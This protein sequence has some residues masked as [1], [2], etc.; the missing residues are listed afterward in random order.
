MLSE[1]ESSTI[2][3]VFD[4]TELGIERRSPKPLANTL[5]I[6]PIYHLLK[7]SD[8]N[9]LHYSQC[10]IVPTHSCQV[11]LSFCDCFLHLLIIWLTV[12]FQTLHSIR[13]RIIY[14]RFNIKS[15]VDDLSRGW[16]ECTLFNSYYTNVE[17]RVLLHSLDCSTLSL[18]LTL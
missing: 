12:S 15:K 4:M 5:L 10:I 18:I 14:F 8:S 7:R 3:W 13:L 1:V 6:M 11:L 9:L 17:R 2:I 16:P